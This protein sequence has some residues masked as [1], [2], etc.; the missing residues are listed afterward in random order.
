MVGSALIFCRT[1]WKTILVILTP[2]LLSPL[3]FPYS[4]RSQESKC[5]FIVL[6]MTVYWVTEAFPLPVTSVIPIALA[7]LLGVASSSRMCKV[8]LEDVSFLLIGGT[9]VA[10]AIEK[11][12]LH[13]RIALR[14]LLL[15]GVE[16]RRLL[17][18][19]MV[20]TAFLSM[21]ISNM[22]TTAMMIPITRALLVKLLTTTSEVNC[23]SSEG[24]DI[25]IEQTSLPSS[26]L[27]VILRERLEVNDSMTVRTKHCE[28]SV[29]FEET[30]IGRHE[31]SG[32]SSR[33]V[34]NKREKRDDKV[35]ETIELH[36][37][38]PRNMVILKIF[39]LCVCY[40]S[41]IGGMAT[42]TGTAPNMVLARM[43]TDLYK[44][45]PVT[46]AKWFFFGFPMSLLL[47][48]GTYVWMY[49]TGFGFRSFFR[50]SSSVSRNELERTKRAVR[51]EFDK[52]GSL[53]FNE[54]IVLIHFVLLV[55]L[56][57][58]RA[59]GSFPGWA[60]FFKPGH[61]TDASV[62]IL[63]ASS[64]FVFPNERPNVLF[65]RSKGDS[66]P[67]RSSPSI[68]TWKSTM[69]KFPW[70][71]IFLCGGGFALS[72]AIKVSGLSKMIAQN[73]M[74]IQVLPGWAACLVVVILTSAVTEIVSNT[75]VTMLLLPMLKELA[76]AMQLHPLYLMLPAT[77]ASSLAFM[78][79]IATPPNAQVFAY[80]DIKVVDMVKSGFILNL[81]GILVI[82]LAINTWGYYVFGLA[83]LPV[84]ALRAAA[85]SAN[86]TNTTQAG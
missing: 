53:K 1:S 76:I 63:V 20:T 82:V 77:A 59:P 12:M 6:I 3:V 80:G 52:L 85:L 48:L 68:L 29:E 43:V 31:E 56:W 9:I 21:W 46:F 60:T 81:L 71:V 38:D 66:S 41:N 30:V 42:L 39:S 75:V 28:K 13:K 44:E 23:Q 36:N 37:L 78:L 83:D 5:G 69:K 32:H 57:L 55:S 73:L 72:E 15:I 22:A 70:G 74:F 25:S 27:T 40:S 24:E 19:V 17:L 79:P 54:V 8:F 47:L 2:V 50:C 4:Q 49:R 33:H 34:R 51:E 35:D 10:I 26:E 65:F 11:T 45:A 14:I 16:P 84:W 62:A 86:S 7:P 18:G 58:L 67:S 64:L 61:V